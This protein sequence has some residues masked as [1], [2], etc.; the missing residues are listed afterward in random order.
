MTPGGVR[1]LIGVLGKRVLQGEAAKPGSL[2]GAA[3]VP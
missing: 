3:A 2:A 1:G